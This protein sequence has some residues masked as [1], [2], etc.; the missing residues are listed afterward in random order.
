MRNPG[1]HTVNHEDPRRNVHD[2]DLNFGD[3]TDIIFKDDPNVRVLNI[4]SSDPDDFI[5]TTDSALN[6]IS[7]AINYIKKTHIFV[8]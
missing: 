5:R 1:T 7:H 8:D 6:A 3:G 4:Q 2:I